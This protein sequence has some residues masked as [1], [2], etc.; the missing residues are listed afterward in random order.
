MQSWLARRLSPSLRIAGRAISTFQVVGSIG[1]AGAG[2]AALAL[3]AKLG[4]SVAVFGLLIAA[5]AGTLFLVA[6]VTLA[7]AGTERLVY[8]HHEIA[9]LGV[10]SALL[11]ALGHPI[12]PYLDVSVLALGVFLAFGRLGCL[13]VGCCHGR[14]HRIGVRYGAE[15]AREGF[16]PWL[17]G[18][19]LF[20]VQLTEALACGALTGIGAADL[21]SGAPPGRVLGNQ[22]IGYA[23]ARTGLEFLRGDAER[24]SWKGLSEAQWTSLALAFAVAAAERAGWIPPSPLPAAVAGTLVIAFAAVGLLRLRRG[25]PHRLLAPAHLGEV[26]RALESGQA[27]PAEPEVVRV[28]TTSLGVHLSSCH[29]SG[30]RLYTLSGVDAAGARALAKLILRLRPARS[31]AT[32][33]ARRPGLFQLVVAAG[34]EADQ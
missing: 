32:L 4:L 22:L 25:S 10:S 14:P 30:Q 19:R 3:G 7:V 26:A 31:N 5:A 17:V 6:W 13:A 2:A 29:V 1:F 9:V 16:P 11:F 8:Y 27:A 20:P 12:L 33:L 24:P 18:V 21:V 28:R 23:L 15:H 34:S